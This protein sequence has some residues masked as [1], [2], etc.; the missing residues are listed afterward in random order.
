MTVPKR[1]PA[2]FSLRPSDAERLAATRLRVTPS[3]IM[4]LQAVEAMVGPISAEDLLRHL[5]E[6]G[7]SMSVGT[8]YRVLNDLTSAGLVARQWIHGLSGTKAVYQARSRMQAQA[9]HRLVCKQCQTPTEFFDATLASHLVQAM[10]TDLLGTVNTSL[11]VLYLCP[12]C[13]SQDETP[14]RHPRRKRAA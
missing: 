7:Q 6:S 3:R 9:P 4:A 10:G 12:A 5:L 1:L 2:D 13:A 14:P 11:D 8:A